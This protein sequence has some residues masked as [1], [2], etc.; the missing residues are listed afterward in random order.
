MGL[1]ATEQLDDLAR[2]WVAVRAT[3]VALDAA[4]SEADWGRR[5]EAA[6]WSVAECVA[7]LNLTSAAM[8]PALRTALEE[9]KRLPPMSGVRYRGTLVGRLLAASMGPVKQIAGIKLGK[10]RTPPPFVPGA[11]LARAEVRRNFLAWLEAEESLVRAARGLAIDAVRVESPFK[12]GV[13][14]DAYSALR[15]VV[16][17]EKRHLVQAER[18]HAALRA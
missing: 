9:A 13:F 16:L 6:A 12:A 5:P 15:I 4:V 17:H 8:V 11:E 1:T 10:V 3:F 18:A 2:Q 7:H 14:Y